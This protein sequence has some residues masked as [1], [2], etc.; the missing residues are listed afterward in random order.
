MGLSWLR[1]DRGASVAAAAWL[2]LLGVAGGATFAWWRLP[3]L[4]QK[5][6]PILMALRHLEQV[7]FMLCALYYLPWPR[8]LWIFG[9]KKP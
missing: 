2:G 1:P 8:L 9:R 5:A 7:S 4:V 6:A 3:H